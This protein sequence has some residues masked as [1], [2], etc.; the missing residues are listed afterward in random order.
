M[1]HQLFYK[2]N[3]HFNLLKAE[4]VG[5]GQVG[6]GAIVFGDTRANLENTI[7]DWNFVEVMDNSAQ[8]LWSGS[9]LTKSEFRKD[10]GNTY[11]GECGEQNNPLSEG[12]FYVTGYNL[13]KNV[14]IVEAVDAYYKNANKAFFVTVEAL[15]G[16]ATVINS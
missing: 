6:T 4:Q 7:H 1:P 16:Y 14:N 11:L 9:F 8:V 12:V 13:T 2:W 15:P 10:Y 3:P 5:Q